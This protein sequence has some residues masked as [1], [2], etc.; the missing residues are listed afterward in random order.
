MI[1]LCAVSVSAIPFS[2]LAT[3]GYDPF[4]DLWLFLRPK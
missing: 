3:L 1:Q 4:Y 2:G